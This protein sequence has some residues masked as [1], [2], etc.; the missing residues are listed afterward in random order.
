MSNQMETGTRLTWWKLRPIGQYGQFKNTCEKSD[1]K[2]IH[3]SYKML[4][5]HIYLY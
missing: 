4:Y 2:P 3:S 1:S 5:T